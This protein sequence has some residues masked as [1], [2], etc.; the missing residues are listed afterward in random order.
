MF[1]TVTNKKVYEYVIEQ[2]Q[3]MILSGVFQKGDKLPSER[4]LSEKMEVSRTSIRE[5][6]RVLET[7]GVVES[8]Q[9]EGTFVCSNINSSFIEPLSMIFML[10]NGEPKDI[11]ELR[12]I[13]E[14]ETVRL[15]AQRGSDEDLEELSNM[16]SKLKLSNSESERVLIDKKIH[17]KIASM[18]GNYL[19]ESVFFT[20]STLFERFIKNAREEMVSC[21]DGNKILMIQHESIVNAII[22]RDSNKAY[23]AMK[24]HLNYIDE[25]IN[26]MNL[27]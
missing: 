3:S 17:E 9:G 5:A 2:I 11:L 16:M 18:S 20:A 8:R 4:E 6:I 21:K 14:L 12:K 22:E 15:A 7:M 13:I 23:N 10:N 26:K 24:D 27:K 1:N 25:Y 19:I